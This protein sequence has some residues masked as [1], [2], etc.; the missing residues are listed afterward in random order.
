MFHRIGFWKIALCLAVCFSFVVP[1]SA[2]AESSTPGTPTLTA[3]SVSASTPSSD[4]LPSVS[5]P[6]ARGANRSRALSGPFT[7]VG[8]PG[9]Y[10]TTIPIT[11]ENTGTAIWTTAS[12]YYLHD[13]FGGSY[14]LGACDGLPPLW[15]CTWYFYYTFS[16]TPG[17]YYDSW[18]MD[19]SGRPFGATTSITLVST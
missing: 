15:S 7:L 10:S 13:A 12:G 6:L 16:F 4:L 5:S 9:S 18:R 1:L 14:S 11:F 3:I 2:S 19:R 8:P 17:T